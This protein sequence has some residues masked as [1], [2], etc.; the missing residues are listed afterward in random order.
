MSESRKG[1]KRSDKNKKIVKEVQARKIV[2][3][4]LQG[5]FIKVWD[6]I[7]DTGRE[8]GID[9]SSIAKCCK[10]KYSN[11]GGF[12]W[13]YFEDEL[14]EKEVSLRNKSKRERPVAQY[15]LSGE[16]ICVFDSITE[17]ALK[18]GV[19]RSGIYRCC[20]GWRNN[21]GGFIWKHFDECDIAE[22]V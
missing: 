20:G 15:S 1:R 3:Y 17:A 8:L 18:T 6:C 14:T 16:L 11:A 2:Q 10:G 19:Y 22:V 5:D 9:I 21:A 7:S 4:T 13:K 12:I